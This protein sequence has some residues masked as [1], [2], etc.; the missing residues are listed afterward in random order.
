M[1]HFAEMVEIHN[2]DG[3]IKYGLLTHSGSRGVG[4][5]IGHYYSALAD[6]VTA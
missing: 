5:K 6:E 2:G 4:N 1:N 3:S